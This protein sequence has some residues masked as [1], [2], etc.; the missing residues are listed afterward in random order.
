MSNLES[1]A[2]I[3]GM[4]KTILNIVNKKDHIVIISKDGNETN[5]IMQSIMRRLNH[6]TIPYEA[7]IQ[8]KII[9]ADNTLINIYS[10]LQIP[11]I[12]VKDYDM[13]YYNP[14]IPHDALDNL[15][16]KFGGK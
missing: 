10:E 1:V 11:R 7:D 15:N 8:E 12:P 16:T 6:Q 5:K 2:G 3:H 13:I 14:M 4:T 9:L